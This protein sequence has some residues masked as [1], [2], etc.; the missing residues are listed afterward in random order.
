MNINRVPL[1]HNKQFIVYFVFNGF[2]RFI[3]MCNL[4][5]RLI[6]TAFRVL[7][8][9][10]FM[11]ECKQMAQRLKSQ[12]RVLTINKTNIIRWNIYRD[13]NFHSRRQVLSV[14]KNPESSSLKLKFMFTC[15][16]GFPMFA[17]F[18]DE[19]DRGK[20]IAQSFLLQPELSL[21]ILWN[22]FILFAVKK[23]SKAFLKFCIYQTCYLARSCLKPYKRA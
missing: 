5:K 12:K 17:F 7:L 4:Q 14:S 8:Q 3:T 6:R 23:I 9:A 19:L 18:N 1:E 10:M 15:K 22:V 16:A 13:N 2:I 21:N 20:E 11:N